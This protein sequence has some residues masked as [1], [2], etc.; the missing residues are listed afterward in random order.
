MSPVDRQQIEQLEAELR[1]ARAAFDDVEVSPDAWQRNQ[2]LLRSG[3]ASRRRTLTAVA[4]GVA[5]LLVVGLGWLAVG[6]RDEA[7]DVPG[8][9][10]PATQRMVE[11][12]QVDLPTGR[13]TLSVG[14]ADDDRGCFGLV[15]ADGGIEAS[16]CNPRD[17]K[18]DDASVAID[19]LVPGGGETPPIAG[20]VDDRTNAVVAWAADGTRTEL[21]LVE[22]P[23]TGLG[24]F[25]AVATGPEST[26]PQR[27]VAY[28]DAGRTRVLQAVDLAERFPDYWLPSTEAGCADVHRVPVATF[29][30]GVTVQASFVDAE[31]SYAGS[32][33]GTREVCRPM[34]E[35]PVAVVRSGDELVLVMAPEVAGIRLVGE[36]R[37][38]PSG[39]VE[40]VGTTMWRAT[41][42]QVQGLRAE[43]TLEFLDESGGVLQQLPVKWII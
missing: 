15:S 38:G 18:A 5:A 29:P 25:G 27:L 30:G 35:A 16:G 26:W 21:P 39:P 1:A 11:V 9:D 33:G 23:G 28:A 36:G 2:D 37:L 8:A 20:L 32:G 24:A 17:P 14:P 13:V 43:D 31:I 34:T 10:R 3:S 12:Q 41:V 40:P 7:A 6:G 19:Y 22:V 42:R 4:A